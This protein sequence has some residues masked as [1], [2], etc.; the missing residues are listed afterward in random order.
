MKEFARNR[1]AEKFVRSKNI[2]KGTTTFSGMK[3]RVISGDKLITYSDYG[4]Q[5]EITRVEEKQQLIENKGCMAATCVL[6][7]VFYTYIYI[8]I[9]IAIT[10]ILYSLP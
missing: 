4:S 10:W 5:C 1:I 2:P 9:Y 3:S 8:Y 7:T 6:I